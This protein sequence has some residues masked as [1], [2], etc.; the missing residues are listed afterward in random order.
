M[1]I[2]FRRT[3][4]AIALQE[5]ALAGSLLFSFELRYEFAMPA[6]VWQQALQAA[7][8]LQMMEAKNRPEPG[9]PAGGEAMDSALMGTSAK[10]G[11][12]HWRRAP[13]PCWRRAGGC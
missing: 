2:L 12:H 5:L 11:K 7:S 4:P 6:R 1:N 13:T 9:G 3:L 8:L 10:I